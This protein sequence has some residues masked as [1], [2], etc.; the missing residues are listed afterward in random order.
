MTLTLTLTCTLNLVG[1][2][3]GGC[4][5]GEG[6]ARET[7]HE[8]LQKFL[9]PERRRLHLRGVVV[10]VVVVIELENGKKRKTNNTYLGRYGCN[11]EWRTTWL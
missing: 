7:G 5:A 3:G 2:D 9:A 6:G 1:V 8:A 11:G 4:G 10:V